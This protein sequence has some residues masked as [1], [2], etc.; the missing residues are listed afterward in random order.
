MATVPLY[1]VPH[2][3]LKRVADPVSNITDDHRK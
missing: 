2:P 1:V 3:V